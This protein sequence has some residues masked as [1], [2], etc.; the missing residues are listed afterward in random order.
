[1][2]RRISAL[3]IGLLLVASTAG[4]Q[5]TTV[6]VTA[7]DGTKLKATYYSPGKP[8]PGMIL[9]HQCDMTRKA[10]ST[11]APA[12]T[13]RGIHVLALDYRGYGENGALPTE[14]PKLPGDVDAALATL[15]SQSGVDRTRI[16][17]GGASCGVDHAVQLARRSGQIKALM[18]LSGPTSDA[19]M[20]YIQSSGIPVFL[21][22]SAD[23]GGPL[24]GTKR[25]VAAS[26]NA[27]TTIREFER[28]GHG[29]PMFGAQPA[30]LPEIADWVARVL[31]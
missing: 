7:A 6:D 20:A 24:P 3:S 9:L 27:A 21:A 10:W 26:K 2:V 31:R 16:A 19:G 29:V 18:L 22:Y 28:A 30:L 25:G 23:E 11:L 1:M 13:E 12:L 5:G 14:Y 15:M 17:A 8:G 4:A